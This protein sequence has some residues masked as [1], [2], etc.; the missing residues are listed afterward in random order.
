M[1]KMMKT[2]RTLSDRLVTALVPRT[3]ARAGCI[4]EWG[5]RT[6]CRSDL[7]CTKNIISNRL[8]R[9]YISSLC[10]AYFRN[11]GACCSQG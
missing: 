7:A 3:E 11:T 5:S 6:R 4:P 8:E 2:M 10:T 9:I 1:M